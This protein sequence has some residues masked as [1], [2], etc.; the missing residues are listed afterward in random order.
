MADSEFLESSESFASSDS[1]AGL[2]GSDLDD[3][4]AQDS[5]G[6]T[7]ESADAAVGE[8]ALKEKSKNGLFS[9]F[10]IF[11]AMLMAALLLILLATFFVFMELTNYGGL[12]G[13]WRTGSVGR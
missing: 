10:N 1:L 12:D 13:S 11:N 9:D 4:V 8:V 5:V 7:V 6:Q 2:S 3:A